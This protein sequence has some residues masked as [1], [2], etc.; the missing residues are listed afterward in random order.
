M[1]QLLTQDPMLFL[2][3][4]LYRV[5]AL[6][7]TLCCHEWAHAYV[8][9][10][11]GDPTARMM[12]RMTLDPRRHLDPFGTI[13]MVTVGFGWAK[14]V[15]VN[16]RNFRHRVADDVKVSLAGIGT[17]LVLFLLCITLAIALN[18]MLWQ[19]E[20]LSAYGSASFL[21]L[22]GI[23]SMLIAGSDQLSMFMQRPWLSPVVGFV[24]LLA[25]MNLMVAL[26]NLLPIPPLDGHHVVND[27]LFKGRLNLSPQ[28]A[29]AGILIIM[30][31]S[32][33]TDILSNVLS[34][35]AAHIHNGVLS[36]FLMMTGG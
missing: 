28:V 20:I 11:C 13:L 22:N 35:F 25:N 2:L 32:F 34:F 19:P 16:P 36:L 26:F 27:L 21:S 3:L 30:V 15:P 8:A 18:S 10:R 7:I 14:P 5:P 23:N 4:S 24:T 6:I 29:Q 12:G 9:Y 1:L 17:N 33:S 31:I